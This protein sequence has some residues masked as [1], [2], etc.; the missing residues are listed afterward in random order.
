[1]CSDKKLVPQFEA[2]HYTV[3][4]LARSWKFSV[5]T[6]RALFAGEPGVI[7]IGSKIS[8]RKRRYVSLRIPAEVAER[9]HARL[10]QGGAR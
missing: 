8:R 5:D 3:A 9:V 6:V 1:M 10:R 2:A 7:Y 4:E